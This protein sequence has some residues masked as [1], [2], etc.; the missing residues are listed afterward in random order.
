MYT[1]GFVEIK[2]VPTA[3]VRPENGFAV[4]VNN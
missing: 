2:F 1:K 3:V 4:W